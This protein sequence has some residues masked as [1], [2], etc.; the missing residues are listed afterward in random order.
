MQPL[1]A[2]MISVTTSITFE[3]T[4]ALMKRKLNIATVEE[5]KGIVTLTV[6]SKDQN[7]GQAAA[8]KV[9]D[10]DNTVVLQDVR[11]RSV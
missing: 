9:K 2:S 10:T 5:A 6:V 4:A 1:S 7:F 8:Q 3:A 11:K